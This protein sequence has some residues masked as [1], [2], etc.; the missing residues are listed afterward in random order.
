[1]RQHRALRS[2]ALFVAGWTA[3]RGTAFVTW[4]AELPSS[5]HVAFQPQPPIPE[6]RADGSGEDMA[7]LTEMARGPA[8]RLHHPALASAAAYRIV[9]SADID[10]HAA[11]GDWAVA[12]AIPAPFAKREERPSQMPLTEIRRTAPTAENSVQIIATS[13]PTKLENRDSAHVQGAAWVLYRGRNSANG[14]ASNGQLGGSQ[15]GVRLTLPTSV[16]GRFADLALTGRVSGAMGE[17]YQGEAG[18]GASIAFHTPVS[19]Q[20]ILER[21]VKLSEGGRNAFAA[22]LVSGFDGRSIGGG[23][24]ASGYAQ[25][26]MVGLRRRDGFVDGSV[27]FE[28]PLSRTGNEGFRLGGGLWGAAQPGVARLDIGPRIARDLKFGGLR[29]AAA[30]EWRHRVAGHARPNSGLALTLGS[31]F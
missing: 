22:T 7:H 6:I 30:L 26:G 13:P 11:T 5:A 28:R 12:P 3:I 15:A 27:R 23:I 19:V 17:P 29:T 20:L 18:L 31:D 1:M 8:R 16:G 10:A 24:R 25:A 14:L 21:R 4:P 2:L 9:H